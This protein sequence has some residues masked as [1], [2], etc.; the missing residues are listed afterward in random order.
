MQL[1]NKKKLKQNLDN[2]INFLETQIFCKYD[3]RGYALKVITIEKKITNVSF[4]QLS[5]RSTLAFSLSIQ[6]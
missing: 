3:K 5:F 2:P 4:C 6:Y 1:A